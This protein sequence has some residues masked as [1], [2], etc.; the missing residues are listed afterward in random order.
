MP[1]YTTH[2]HDLNRVETDP[3]F[4]VQLKPYVFKRRPSKDTPKVPQ[5]WPIAATGKR[6]EDYSNPRAKIYNKRGFDGEYYLQLAELLR[7]Q[8]PA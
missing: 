5:D 6:E 7:G 4:L 1:A 3:A 2:L 8:T